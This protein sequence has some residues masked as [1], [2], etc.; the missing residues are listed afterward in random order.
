MFLKIVSKLLNTLTKAKFLKLPKTF[1]WKF[2]FNML[3][4][5]LTK[6]NLVHKKTGPGLFS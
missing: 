4:V 2:L 5:K 3:F 6:A 1:N